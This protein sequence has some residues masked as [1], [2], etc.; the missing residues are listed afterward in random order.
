MICWICLGLLIIIM[1]FLMFLLIFDLKLRFFCLMVNCSILLIFL[2]ISDREN[3]IFLILSWLDLIFEKLRILL[4]IVSKDV[5]EFWMLLIKFCCFLLR[6]VVFK[7]FVIFKILVI[8]VWI[9]WDM[10]VRNW[11]F[12]WVVFLVVVLL[13]IVLCFFFD[14]F[15]SVFFCFW[16]FVMFIIILIMLVVVLWEVIFFWLW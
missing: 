8:G 13:V 16:I 2:I 6:V 15:C 4:I 1:L 3:C 14:C 5:V 9:L 10:L 12:S 7:S 11:F